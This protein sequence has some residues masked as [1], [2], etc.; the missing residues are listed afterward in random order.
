[1]SLHFP[2]RI[3]NFFWVNV[4]SKVNYLRKNI[5]SWVDP[6]GPG[7]KCTKYCQVFVVCL[8]PNFSK[9]TPN[10][11][12]VVHKHDE[13]TDFDKFN[14]IAD[15]IKDYSKHMMQRHLNPIIFALANEIS[16]YDN[17]HCV[18]V[19]SKSNEVIRSNTLKISTSG[20]ARIFEPH[21]WHAV[22]GFSK[23]H[24]REKFC[25]RKN[26]VPINID[27]CEIQEA[28]YFVCSLVRF[29]NA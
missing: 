12:P 17:S 21:F 13:S 24:R 10:V 22:L 11:C 3:C 18:Q 8:D 15:H 28:E 14:F 25:F 27:N 19:I 29:N 5:K 20:Y 4:N 2:V 23:H 9:W 1:M 6:N 16:P 7:H 26:N